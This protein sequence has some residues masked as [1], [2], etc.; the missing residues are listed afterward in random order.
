MIEGQKIHLQPTTPENKRLIFDWLTQWNELEL[1]DQMP[2]WEEF[3]E[4]YLPFFFDGSREEIGRSLLI[5]VDDTPIGQINY[6]RTPN[7]TNCYELDIWMSGE[8]YC[9]KGFGVAALRNLSNHLIQ[10]FNSPEI[11]IRPSENNKRA[12]R[13][14]EKA[15]FQRVDCDY[16]QH[17]EEY[18]EPD[19]QHC[20]L[21]IHK[22]NK[23]R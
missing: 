6:H 10:K 14:Y 13:A 1:Y 11:I 19:S 21:M 3:C 20:I 9:A 18:G 4:D 16:T 15:G 17:V 7:R 22:E 2:S 12:I 8:N 23:I 5:L